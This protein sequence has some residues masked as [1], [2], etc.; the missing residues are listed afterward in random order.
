MFPGGDGAFA[1]FLARQIRYPEYGRNNAIQGNVILSFEVEKDGTL[2]NFQV[3]HSVS[4]G[5]DREALRVIKMSPKWTPSTLYGVPQ[6][7]RH[8][9]SIRFALN[10]M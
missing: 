9:V 5:L 7:V 8:T 4:K 6:K 10:T 3:V 1:R 2:S